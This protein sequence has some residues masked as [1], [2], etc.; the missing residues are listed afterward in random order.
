MNGNDDPDPDPASPLDTHLQGVLSG[1]GQDF[2]TARTKYGVDPTLLASI[3]TL[4]SGHGSS[5]AATAFNNPTGMMDP[6]NPKQFQKF[7]SIP[8]AIDATASDLSRNYLQKGLT[9]IPQ[10]GAVYSPVR[11]GGKPVANDPKG[12]NKGW[13]GDVQK[14]YTQMGG[15]KT[16]FGPQSVGVGV[17]MMG[18]HPQPPPPSPNLSTPGEIPPPPSPAPVADS[19]SDSSSSSD[20]LGG[21]LG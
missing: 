9:T 18:G 20:Q 5:H 16:F 19:D 2:K 4:E 3:A 8:D 11:V 1:H 13:P 14:L 12:T 21:H 7:N 15:T 10:I 17:N 6:K